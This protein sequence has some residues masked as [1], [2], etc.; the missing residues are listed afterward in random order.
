MENLL[1]RFELPLNLAAS[2]VSVALATPRDG[3]ECR[4]AYTNCR[5]ILFRRMGK[6]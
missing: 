5:D 3:F 6:W 2:A 1:R 4:A